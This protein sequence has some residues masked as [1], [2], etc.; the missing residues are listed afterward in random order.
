MLPQPAQAWSAACILKCL[1]FVT[2]LQAKDPLNVQP[3]LKKCFE[4]IKKLDM[5]TPNEE[6]KQHVSTGEVHTHLPAA[7]DRLSV[8][9]GL[10]QRQVTCC[11]VYRLPSS[12]PR[13][14]PRRSCCPFC[15]FLPH[16]LLT[17]FSTD[18][19]CLC[20]TLRPVVP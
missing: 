2:P 12:L 3:H 11:L 14:H 19:A 9:Q 15:A 16:R 7:F 17:L 4:G 1:L 8:L 20:D 10:K 6:R 5:S 13:G 18:A